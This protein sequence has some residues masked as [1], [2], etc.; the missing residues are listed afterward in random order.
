LQ[1][2][3]TFSFALSLHFL[4]LS[5]SLLLSFSHFLLATSVF[6]VLHLIS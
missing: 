6:I 4:P 5:R 2:K 3:Y 1:P